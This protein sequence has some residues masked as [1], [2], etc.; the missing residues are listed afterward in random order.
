MA[1]RL[2]LFDD[3]DN[4][5]WLRDPVLTDTR[6]ES[7]VTS[8]TITYSLK[9][10]AGTEIVTGSFA[11]VES[12]KWRAAIAS[13]VAITVGSLYTLEITGDC[14]GANFFISVACIGRRRTN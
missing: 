6:D 13:D 11:H 1:K 7:A 12:G 2:A 14:D 8:G 3:N 10:E 5:V 4:D 9:N